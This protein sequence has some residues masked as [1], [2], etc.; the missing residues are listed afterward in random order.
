VPVID[1]DFAF[2]DVIEF[3]AFAPLGTST[4]VIQWHE[5]ACLVECPFSDILH[6][7]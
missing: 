1:R 4:R 6:G 3:P 5:T 2:D 7:N